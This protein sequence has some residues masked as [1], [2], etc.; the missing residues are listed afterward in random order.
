MLRTVALFLGMLLFVCSA[1]AQTRPTSYAQF[2]TSVG[3]SDG[4][5]LTSEIQS[6]AYN[7]IYL[8][9][10]YYVLNN[11]VVI[12][13][14]TTLYLHGADRM[15]TVLVAANPTQPMFIV[16]NAPLLNFA[17]LHFWPTRN[18]P[19]SLNFRAIVTSNT[20]PLVF[21]M[22][23]CVIEQSMVELAGPGQY[24]F[25][26]EV[27]NPAGKVTS[28]LLVNHPGADVFV[29]GG[30]ASNGNA[31]LQASDFAFVWQKLGRLRLYATTFEGG[32]GPS[33][34]RIESGSSIGPHVIANVR[35]EGVN[36][37][38]NRT[39]AISRLLYVPST[40]DHVDV[41]L[42]SNGGA[43]DTGPLTDRLTRMNCKLVLYNGAGT[44]WLLGNRAE[45]PCGRSL[46]EGNAP[47]ATIVS[48]GNL[49]SSPQAFAPTFG[50][51]ITAEDLF[52]NMMW[53]GGDQSNPVVR[54]IPNGS[55][56]PKLS[57]YTNVPVVPQDVLPSAL[58]RPTITAALPGMIDVKAP[59]Y[60]AK[61][62]GTTD[63]TATIQAAL[64]AG[65]DGKTPKTLY[66]PAGTYRVTNTLYL[67]D[68][69][70]IACQ[71]AFPYGGWIAG[72]GSSQ[73]IITM[74]P[75]LKK[76]VFATDGLSWATIQGITF[77]T[78]TYQSGDPGAINF[79]VEFRPGYI[80]SQLDTFY[81]VA[82][83]GG[84]AGFATG[85]VPPTGGNCSS[86]AVFGGRM[87]NSHIGFVSGHYN[88]IANGVSDSSFVGN[89]YNIGSWTQDPVNLPAGGTFFAYNSVSSGTRIQDALFAGS[90]S[91]NTWYFYNWVSDAPLFFV[92]QP[93]AATWPLM[94]DRAQLTPKPG[95]PYL[96]D[97]ASAQGPLFLFSTLS[98]SGVRVGQGGLG[99]GY[100]IKIGT[101]APDWLTA[102]S[103]SPMG[104]VDALDWS[105]PSALGTPA[106]SAPGTPTLLG[107]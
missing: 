4:A 40:S 86:M 95:Q 71:N 41:L 9:P 49:I 97:L 44:V 69:A 76:G 102:I 79:D 52:N 7:Y 55:P 17:G 27:F 13:R 32:L 104:V 89:D 45:G 29:F 101:S 74:D 34:I 37:V 15:F 22:L 16:K 87:M 103:S 63:D 39:G 35:S 100:A 78:W 48:V 11:P 70:G 1:A 107:W 18:S 23:D 21:E 80:P 92:S 24:Q 19:P 96:F 99:Q 98:R 20:A 47:T 59:P 25:Q 58:T 90:A 51:I 81:D 68:H 84:F 56:T 75:S 54:W 10:G 46:V 57:S 72:A 106:P 12:D 53:T 3:V 5:A 66:F 88:A 64:N 93:T 91:G 28:S 61:G 94:Y 14:T 30:D 82:F 26:A 8:R 62:D 36:G 60:N 38:L 67:N 2:D 85:V 65:C 6:N 73:T 42:K 105:S 77:R 31:S 33:D 50:Q 83:D 43:W